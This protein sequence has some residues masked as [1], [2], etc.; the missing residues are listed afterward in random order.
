MDFSQTIIRSNTIL[1]CDKY[2]QTVTFYRDILNLQISQKTEWLVEFIL[3]G[4]SFLSIA[5][6][7]RTTIKSANGDGITISLKIEN[8]DQVY[9]YF[10]DQGITA[11]EIKSVWNAKTIYVYDPE[12]HRIE[13]WT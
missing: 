10:C 1:Y 5:D 9:N 8:I 11:S 6:A 4:Q 2:E 12:G 13:F 3:S 7:G